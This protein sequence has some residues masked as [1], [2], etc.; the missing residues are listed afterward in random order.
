MNLIMV[1]ILSCPTNCLSLGG[2]GTFDII[3][4]APDLFAAAVPICGIADTSK[5][6]LM[7]NTPLW[8]FHG[9]N[10]DINDVNYSRIIVDAL[11]KI[12]KP[13][14]YTEYKGRGHFIWEDVFDEPELLPWIFSQNKTSQSIKQHIKSQIKPQDHYKVS[15]YG[16]TM[17]ITWPARDVAPDLVEFFT[18]DGKLLFRKVVSPEYKNFST[19]VSLDRV[20]TGISACIIR[21]SQQSRLLFA[22]C[23]LLS[24]P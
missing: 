15:C 13:P 2:E 14:K 24:A 20:L 19:T 17:K 9:N 10:D 12:G 23:K 21:C 22:G 4:R 11:T 3:T 5:A 18:V 16:S 7:G 6:A 8:I 1:P